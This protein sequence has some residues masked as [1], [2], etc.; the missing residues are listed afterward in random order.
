MEDWERRGINNRISRLEDRLARLERKGWE[1]S[2]FIFRLVMHGF[3]VAFVV[4][5][6]VAIV[7]GATH[8]G[9]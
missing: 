7:V 2:D 4:L 3:T 9:R 6:I 8:L 5:A 1:R